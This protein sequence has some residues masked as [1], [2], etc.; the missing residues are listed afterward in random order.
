MYREA[1]R[2][3]RD[4]FYDPNHHG[5]N[6]EELARAYNA[7]LP[8]V[9]RRVYL[10]RLFMR[11]LGHVSVSHLQVGGGDVP[12]S[13]GAGPPVGD[14]GAEF[15]LDGARYRF[16]KI[17]RSPHFSAAVGLLNAPLDQPG[18]DVRE[19]DFLIAVD[20][21]EV[22]T[23][24]NVWARFLGKVNQPVTLTVSATAAGDAPRTYTVVPN[25]G[26]GALRNQDRGE[27]NRRRVDALSGGRVAYLYVGGYNPSGVDSVI[28]GLIGMRDRQA[29]I[30]DQR[31]NGGGT[32]ADAL[33]EA[34][35]RQPLYEYAYRYGEGF[36]TPPNT[37]SGP[38]VL[39]TNETNFS[40]AETFAL[41]FKLSR[42][43][44]IVGQRT[45]G[46]GIGAALFQPPLVDGGRIAIP[47][48]AAFNP[49]GS[50]DIE[51]H[52]V[53]PDVNVEVL[54]RDWKEGRDPQLERAVEVALAALKQHKPVPHRRPPYPIHR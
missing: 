34:L 42:A 48:R 44:T 6:L 28:R 19:G 53:V 2:Q 37:F 16:A 12:G 49:A 47:N 15:V 10:N 41:M 43:G 30:I 36:Q 8:S 23:S 14:I 51:N 45:G 21:Q 52:G 33:I 3:M 18:I 11:M 26:T 25:A 32:T 40:A 27:T 24:T 54:P 7:L 13:A 1:W 39:I 35:N 38:K 4:T 50:W 31:N 22:D 29:L 46:G 9:T 17:I 5:Q 20:G